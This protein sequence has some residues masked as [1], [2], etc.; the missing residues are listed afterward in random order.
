MPVLASFHPKCITNKGFAESLELRE[1]LGKE[2]EADFFK[3]VKKAYSADVELKNEKVDSLKLLNEPVN[4]KYEMNMD[5]GDED[6]MYFNP[7]LAEQQ[8]DNPFAAAERIYPVEMPYCWDE[9]Y[10]MNMAIPDGYTIDELPKSTRLKL[11]GDEG[12]FEYLIGKSG[13]NIQVRVRLKLEKALFEPEDYQTLRDFFAFVV[14]KEAEQVVFKK[15][16]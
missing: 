7:L 5:M 14:K 11:N 12:M 10:V 15:V 1:K 2:S 9:T 6:I 13:D 8:K 4:V 3:E 16:K